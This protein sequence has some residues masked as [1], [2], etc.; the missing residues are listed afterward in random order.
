MQRLRL[1]IFSYSILIES[2]WPEVLELLKK[3]FWS[4]FR[5]IELTEAIPDLHLTILH[6]A[7]KPGWAN[8]KHDFCTKN[9]MTID[10]GNKRFCNYFDKLYSEIDLGLNKALL[11]SADLDKMHET[12]YLLILSRIGKKLDTTGIHK[13]HAFAVA[14]K[15][16]VLICMMPSGGGKSTLLTELLM[17]PDVRMLSDDIPMVNQKGDILPFPLKIGLNQIKDNFI[18][19]EPDLNIYQ[20]RRTHYGLKQL[21]CTAG[22]PG[23]VETEVKKYRSIILI[24]GHKSQLSTSLKKVPFFFNLPGLLIHG[25]IGFGTPIIFEYFW[26][27][28]IRDFFVKS[29]IFLLRLNAF[30]KLSFKAEHYH[31]RSGPKPG[32]T[33]K[34]LIKLM[35]D[36][37]G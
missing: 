8:L 3:D 7:S 15:D 24:E 37:A 26:E 33:A 6:S 5:E 17:L 9:A 10:Q 25:L 4:F 12:A 22:L 27:K 35:D 2:D 16:V 28:G 19:N 36:Y 18:V 23:K 21:I 11:Q 32:E 14:R 13:L 31:L 30:L 20:M 34:L 1:Q 29:R